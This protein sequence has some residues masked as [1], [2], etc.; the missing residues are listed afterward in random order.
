MKRVKTLISQYITALMKI[1]RLTDEIDRLKRKTDQWRP[2][3]DE[4]DDDDWYGDDSEE[5]EDLDVV[6]FLRDI[7]FDP[8]RLPSSVGERMAIRD[9][10]QA[11]KAVRG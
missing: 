11:A 5:Y 6:I 8:D 2:G 10:L 9:L 1:D 7:G 4:D 3:D